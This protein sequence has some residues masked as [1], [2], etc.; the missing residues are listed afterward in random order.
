MARRV[1][2]EDLKNIEFETSEDV[3]VTPTFDHMGLREDLLRGIYAYGFEKPSAIQQRSIKPIVKGRDVI[4]QAQSGTGKTATFSISILQCLDT[5]IRETQALVLSPTRE[6]AVQ[7]QKVIL[8]LGDYMSV[9]CHACIGGTNIGD[10]IRKLDYGQHVVSG[11][12]GRV[13][14]MIRRRNLRTRAIKMLVLDEADEM[15]NKGFKEQ[16]YDVYRYLPPATQVCLISATLPHEI[17]EMTNKFMTDPIRILVKRDELTLEGIKQFFVAVEREEWKFDTLCDLYDTLTITQAVIFCNTKRKVD[18]LTEKMREA[19]FTVSSMHGDMVQKEREAIMKEFRSGASRVLITTDVWARGI[20]VQQVSLVINY[21]LPNNREL[22]IHRIGR[23]GRFGRK[24]VAINFVKSDDIRILRDIE[25]YYATQIDEMPMNGLRSIKLGVQCE[26]VVK[27]PRLFERYPFPIL[28][29][30]AFLKLAD[31]FRVAD[32]FKEGTL[33]SIASIISERKNAHH[34]VVNGLD[35]H[36]AVEVDAAIYAADKF[37]GKSKVF[38][39][40]I[41][42]KIAEMIEDIATPV[43]LKLQLIPIMKNMYHDS[44][45][46]AKARGICLHLLST[47]PAEKFVTL[48]LETL[49][50]LAMRSLADVHSQIELL[51]HHLRTDPRNSVKL[52]SLKNL[53]LLARKSPQL[54]KYNSVEELLSFAITCPSFLLKWA[55]IQVLTSLSSSFAFQMF[56]SRDMTV[57]D[58]QK[59][60][61]VCN[62]CYQTQN[63]TLSSKAIEFYTNVAVAYKKSKVCMIEV[64]RDLIEG[65]RLAITTQICV[66]IWSSESKDKQALLLCLKCL[67][68]LVKTYQETGETFVMELTQLLESASDDNCVK[69][70]ECLAALGSINHQLIEENLGQLLQV[71][72]SVSSKPASKCQLECCLYLGTVFFQVAAGEAIPLDVQNLITQSI[73]KSMDDWF[74][75]KLGRQAMRYG[76]FRIASEIFQNLSQHVASEHN[77]FWLTGLHGVCAAEACVNKS[78]TSTK[79]LTS[80]ISEMLV[81]YQQGLVSIKAASTSVGTMVF[82]CEFVRLRI[83]LLQTHQQLVHT[84]NTFRTCPPPAIATAMAV[85]NRHEISRVSQILN[86]LGKCL[87]EYEGLSEKFADLY[88]SAFDADTHTLHTILLY[89]QFGALSTTDKDPLTVTIQSIQRDL[90]SIIQSH[91]SEGLTHQLAISPQQLSGL[92]PVQVHNETQLTVKVEGIVQHGRY[93]DLFRK[94][95]KVQITATS[96]LVNRTSNSTDQKNSLTTTNNLSQSVEP[97]NDYFSVNFLLT[98]PVTGSHS[99]QIRADVVDENETLWKTGPSS[100]LSIKSY[101]DSITKKP[102]NKPVRTSFGQMP[103]SVASSSSSSNQ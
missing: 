39:A 6:L 78:D 47:F 28:I 12:P 48:T 24:G 5:Q 62:I 82:Q 11:T 63:A 43:H 38:A 36:D 50:H 18:W 102:V 3:D 52:T 81:L 56:F 97:H 55:C 77:F 21:D 66:S 34:S 83:W 90:N 53:N 71:Y 67:V 27:F 57:S 92:D 85:S 32:A 98:F 13:F 35:S 37:S 8:A 86:Q 15:L 1:L 74:G 65:A 9:Q 22:Y 68:N 60:L 87:K 51:I 80:Q 64:E 7:I 4:A 42:S 19:N 31:V 91:S 17:L 93:R 33:G 101:D 45:T 89:L 95:A 69:L 46:A 79:A 103:P 26:A 16:I 94:V 29:N 75:Y 30:S 61:E 84:C 73:T 59:V 72:Q 49:T 41:C 70:C 2:E 100:S 99:V 88:Q 20:D 96:E 14:D 58:I 25:Q 40:N 44:S 54:W 23:S 10:D 76:Q